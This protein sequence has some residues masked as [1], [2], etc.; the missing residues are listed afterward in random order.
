MSTTATDEYVYINQNGMTMC[1]THGG[2]GLQARLERD[3]DAVE[4]LTDLD[5]WM[6]FSAKGWECE[7]CKR[8]WS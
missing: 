3:P 8:G 4:I 5:H 1:R 6:R 7:T 2:S